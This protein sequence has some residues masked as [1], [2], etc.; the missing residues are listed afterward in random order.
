MAILKLLNFVKLYEKQL[1][2]AEYTIYIQFFHFQSKQ[3]F[4]SYLGRLQFPLTAS[5]V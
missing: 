3:H 5:S 2:Q 1:Y 4:Q